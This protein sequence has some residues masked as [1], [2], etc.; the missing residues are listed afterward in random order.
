MS[1]EIGD[2]V[3]ARF[4]NQ[5]RTQVAVQSFIVTDIQNSI[6]YGGAI[7]CDIESGWSVELVSKALENLNLPTSLSE[8][9]A[10]DLSNIKTYL[11]GKETTWRDSDGR[12]YQLNRI[13]RWEEG[14]V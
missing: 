13:V 12:L 10:Y 3:H 7:D 9:T 1:I 11:T 6:Y 14:H 8:I 2:K 4:Y 5:D